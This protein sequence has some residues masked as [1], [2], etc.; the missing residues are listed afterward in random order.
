MK[1]LITGSAGFIGFHL[2]KRLLSK[3]ISVIGID[4][5]NSYYSSSLKYDRNKILINESNQNQSDYFYYEKKIEDF[6]SLKN[7]FKKHNPNIVINLAAQAGVRH[8]I[9]NPSVYIQSNLVGFA[10]FKTI[11]FHF[12]LRFQICF[13]TYRT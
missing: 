5:F 11:I 12:N 8:S 3:G 1:V 10:N 13:C 4:D 7:I 6:Q 2:S 9:E